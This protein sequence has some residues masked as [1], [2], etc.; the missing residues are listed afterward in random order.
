MLAQNNGSYASHGNA[1]MQGGRQDIEAD[2]LLAQMM[3]IQS[4]IK[5]HGVLFYL[6]SVH[7]RET[8]T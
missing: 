5:N 6:S 3:S 8:A 7:A 2:L 4:K 1:N